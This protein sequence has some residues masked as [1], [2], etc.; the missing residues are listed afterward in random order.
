MICDWCEHW[1]VPIAHDDRDD[2]YCNNCIQEVAEW[3]RMLGKRQLIAGDEVILD[4]E[5]N[6]DNVFGMYL[7]NKH[8]EEERQAYKK[9]KF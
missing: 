3:I 6:I 1:S 9:G 5:K 7:E 8:W 4:P 2:I